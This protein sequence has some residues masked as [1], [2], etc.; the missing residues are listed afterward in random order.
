MRKK[1]YGVEHVGG[2]GAR[3]NVERDRS[4]PQT[5]LRSE[6]LSGMPGAAAH[7]ASRGPKSPMKT[8]NLATKGM[9]SG[10]SAAAPAAVAASANGRQRKPSAPANS[11]GRQ[12][13]IEERIAAATEQ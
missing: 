11:S 8:T 4:L 13:K 10:R 9:A 5:Q 12:Q 1:P 3:S 7:F 6:K 2:K